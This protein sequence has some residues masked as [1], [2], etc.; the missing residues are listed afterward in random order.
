MK[1]MLPHFF[2]GIRVSRNLLANHA[3]SWRTQYTGMRHLDNYGL[4]HGVIIRRSQKSDSLHLSRTHCARRVVPA[5]A[6]P[7]AFTLFP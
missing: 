5:L 3:Q 6:P 7:M 1:T 2:R 4:S